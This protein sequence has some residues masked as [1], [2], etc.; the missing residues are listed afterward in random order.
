MKTD[1]ALDWNFF[2]D[3]VLQVVHLL[4]QVGDMEGDHRRIEQ[5]SD[6]SNYDMLYWA[7][8]DKMNC[9]YSETRKGQTEKVREQ[10]MR[11]R[12]TR[13][14]V[15]KANQRFADRYGSAT[16]IKVDECI[17]QAYCNG[18]ENGIKYYK[19]IPTPPVASKA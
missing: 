1:I 13:E 18:F 8:R 4:D 16:M 19:N 2:L 7:Q 11:E 9:V 12:I 14:E 6:H 5:A 15:A 10:S 3:T 17:T